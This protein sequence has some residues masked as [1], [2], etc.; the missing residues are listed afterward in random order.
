MRFCEEKELTQTTGNE[1][2]AG[3]FQTSDRMRELREEILADWETRIRATIEPAGQL[4]HPILI[5]TL[6]VLLDNIVAALI[7][8]HPLVTATGSATIASE[9]GG[10]R[11]RL[12]GYD[13]KAIICE[14]QILRGSILTVLKRSGAV[15]TDTELAVIDAFIDSAIR[16]SVTA[17]ALVQST[18]RER[19]VATLSHDLRNPLATATSC[20][21]LIR[22]LSDSPEI[23]RFANKIVESNNRIDRM[24][25]DLLDAASFKGGARLMLNISQF[26]ILD[27]AIEVEEA[28]SALPETRLQVEGKPTQ[29]WWDRDAIKRALEN[30]VVNAGKYSAPGEPVQLA[31]ESTHERLILSVHNKGAPIPVDEQE[32]IF[33]VFRRAEAAKKGDKRGWGVGLPYVRA[34]AESHGGSIGVDSAQEKGTTFFLDIPLDARPF[35]DAPT[36]GGV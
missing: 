11:A 7:P 3:P 20:A 22:H 19:F 10:E 5:N 29:G 34:V 16:E 35:H 1:S 32:S 21:E 23:Q 12:S 18:F 33:K 25:Q 26:D 30:L 6:P 13:P 15:L 27:V 9:H 2:G 4:G 36:L 28:S 31:I 24:I 8:D 14:Y 17:F